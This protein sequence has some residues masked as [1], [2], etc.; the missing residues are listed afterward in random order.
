VTRVDLYVKD[1]RYIRR[2]IA[3][4]DAQLALF[5]SRPEVYGEVMRVGL[6]G[7]QLRDAHARCERAWRR[8]E[9]EASEGPHS[10]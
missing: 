8:W 7:A 2:Q 9:R 10:L 1:A 3:E 5:L 6:Y 4:A